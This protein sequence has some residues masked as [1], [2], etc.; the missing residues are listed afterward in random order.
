MQALFDLGSKING[1]NLAYAKKPG[2]HIRP[3]NEEAPKIDRLHLNTFKMVIA[4][5]S[6]RNNLKKV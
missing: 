6:F 5:F 1:M 3:T 4:R 2:L